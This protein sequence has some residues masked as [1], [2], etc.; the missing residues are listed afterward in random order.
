MYNEIGSL[1]RDNIP[2]VQ[3]AF[4]RFTDSATEEF[5]VSLR[6]GCLVLLKKHPDVW[7]S[8]Y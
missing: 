2:Q 4:L 5:S 7:M 1:V 8:K 6:E 3:S